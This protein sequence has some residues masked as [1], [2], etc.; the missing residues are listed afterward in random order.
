M[1]ACLQWLHK[2]LTLTVTVV[3]V[4]ILAISQ[5]SKRW[6]I[7]GDIL[8]SSITIKEAL[9]C[10]TAID[11]KFLITRDDEYQSISKITEI[12]IIMITIA[13]DTW[14]L[15]SHWIHVGRL[16]LV[17]TVYPLISS[18][19]N[20]LFPP[21]CKGESFFLLSQRGSRMSFCWPSQK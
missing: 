8:K 19:L 7:M 1:T 9:Q 15:A 2:W 13:N 10:E 16:C 4:Y 6:T 11:P 18:L 21:G 20:T 12:I 14:Y 5:F 3:F 17:G